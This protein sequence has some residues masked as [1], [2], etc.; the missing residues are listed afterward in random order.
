[1]FMPA[2]G[3]IILEIDTEEDI[4]K[5]FENTEYKLIGHTRADERIIIGDISI[6][7]NEAL[8]RWK[9]P[10][11]DVFPTEVSM[12]DD[13]PEEYGYRANVKGTGHSISKPRVLIPVFPGSSGEYDGARA[14]E[15]AGAN[16]DTMLFKNMTASDVEDSLDALV[17][18]IKD[19]QIIM[20]PDGDTTSLTAA[21]M[22]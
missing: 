12:T 18:A 16:V 19:S 7:L 13:H 5:L 11:E 15:D 14:F 1:I 8:E 21:F 4:D 9:A 3:S 6:S 2:Y 17:A 10:L 22:H 20:L